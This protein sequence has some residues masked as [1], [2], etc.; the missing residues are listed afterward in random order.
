MNSE[1]GK[2][3]AV[4][5]SL[6]INSRAAHG[7]WILRGLLIPDPSIVQCQLALRMAYQSI[8]WTDAGLAVAPES[9][10]LLLMRWHNRIPSAEMMQKHTEHFHQGLAVWREALNRLQPT[11]R[12]P[13]EGDQ[14]LQGGR[15]HRIRQHILG[16][17]R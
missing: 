5:G 3:S 16:H 6:G 13:I 8:R 11:K 14:H 7:G 10:D 17:Q 15:E 1:T 9:N 2:R 4:D 12:T